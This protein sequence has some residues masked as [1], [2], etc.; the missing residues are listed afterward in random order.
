MPTSV[1]RQG[2]RRLRPS[3]AVVACG[4]AFASALAAQA[5]SP[6]FFRAA[7]PADFLRGEIENLSLDDRGQLTLGPATDLV[8]EAAAPFLWS[9]IPG[10][11]GSLFVGTGNEGRVYRVDAAGAGSLVF[12]ATELDAHALATAPDG[13]LY[14]GTSPDGRI[15]RIDQS[16][17]ATPFFD[18]EERYVW[19]LAVDRSGVVYAGTGESGVVYRI[20]PD[21]TGTRF[22]QAGAV[23]VTALAFDTG[24][25]LLVGTGSPGRVL[26]VDPS[27]RAFLLLDSPYRE[28]SALR[29]DGR[30]Q[31]YV[32]ATNGAGS[33]PVSSATSQESAT[34]TGQPG[35]PVA[36]V[37][38]EVTSMAVA[39]APAA[40]TSA[41]AATTGDS[42]LPRG[43]VYRIAPDG[44][45]DKLWEPRDDVPYDLAFD[46]NG[47]LMVATGNQ[48]KV[49]RLDG[50]PPQ[51]T[52]I[53]RAAAQQV[54]ALH[55][56]AAG[57]LYLATSNPGKL[58]RLSEFSLP[59]EGQIGGRD[60]ERSLN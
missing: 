25:N 12:D 45:W 46:E 59:L 29:F 39:D 8:Y 56:D 21:G 5:S 42:R 26:R 13:T 35:A 9:V 14:V 48:G 23:H 3:A 44:L 24:G 4:L 32:A 15:Y 19:A 27:S 22:Y 30:G 18:P 43:A 40:D 10:P 7:T 50:E 2:P 37:T 53:A 34:S 58:L 20:S 1:P 57:R 31:L 6:R 41:P 60:D 33:A 52:L 51:P 54:T 28:I 17:T 16:G 38:T 36:I 55:R 49:F 11:G 47:R